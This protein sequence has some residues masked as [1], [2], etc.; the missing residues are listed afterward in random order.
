MRPGSGLVVAEEK[1]EEVVVVVDSIDGL[2]EAFGCVTQ[3][4]LV[5]F[6]DEWKLLT[7]QYRPTDTDLPT[8]FSYRHRNTVEYW[9]VMSSEIVESKFCIDSNCAVSSIRHLSITSSD[10]KEEK[11]YEWMNE[12]M[13]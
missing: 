4:L 9:P 12:W 3:W 8:H 1:E 7:D 2:L 5:K 6:T 11:K 13:K 10:E